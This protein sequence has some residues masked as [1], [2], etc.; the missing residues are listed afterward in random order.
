MPEHYLDDRRLPSSVAEAFRMPDRHGLGARHLDRLHGG[1]QLSE[2]AG[3]AARGLTLRLPVEVKTCADGSCQRND[4]G[5][6][7]E[8]HQR[9]R[10]TNRDHNDHRDGHRDQVASEQGGEPDRLYDVED[11]VV[12]PIDHVA[13]TRPTHN[14]ATLHDALVEVPA[15]QRD[16]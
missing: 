8:R 13:M 10:G 16:V 9:H 5:H 11:V 6:W 7:D 4:G 12:E 15:H 2:K 1:E 3:N 14:G